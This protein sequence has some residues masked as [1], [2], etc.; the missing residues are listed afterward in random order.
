M[1]VFSKMFREANSHIIE[2][3]GKIIH[4]FYRFDKTGKY[5]FRF[6]FNST[7]SEFIQAI[8]MFF[9]EFEGDIFLNKNNICKEK[10]KFSHFAFYEDSFPKQFD[11]NINIKSGHL[12]ICNGSDADGTRR[13]CETL[14]WGCA[15][16]VET[17]SENHFKFFCNDHEL[18]D[19]FD[20]LI[21]ELE[22]I[23]VEDFE[24]IKSN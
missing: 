7:N 20:D 5:V 8:V 1:V 23:E 12:T 15:M 21:F 19:D 6:K 17:L 16:I 10:K 4:R 3:N 9:G 22:I 18:D 24:D 2:H 11:L 13:G 14:V